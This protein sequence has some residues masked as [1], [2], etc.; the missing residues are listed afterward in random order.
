MSEAFGL[1][2]WQWI[3][4]PR[5]WSAGDELRMVADAE[6]DLWRTTHYGYVYDSAHMF[7]RVLPGDL[8]V[9]ATFGAEYAEQYDQAGVML[10]IDENNWI[11]TGAEFVDGGMSLSVVVT[12][13]LSDWSVVPLAAKAELVTVDLVREGDAV[14]VRY[15]LD[16][17]EPSTLLRLAYF[18]P[19]IPALAWVMCA[20]PVGKGFPVRFTSVTFSS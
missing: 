5:E 10:R 7:G 6:T 13:D 11:K 18:P 14:T 12:R 19:A 16:G 15:G 17:A 2:G 9:T 4:E 1:S 8:G 20:A 3:N